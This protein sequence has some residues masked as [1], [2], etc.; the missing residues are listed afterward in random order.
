MIDPKKITEADCAYLASLI[1]RCAKAKV[2][3]ESRRGTT[4]RTIIL[5]FHGVS[6]EV[7]L[8]LG[9]KFGP[10]ISVSRQAGNEITFVSKAAAQVCVH[11]YPYLLV[12]KDV[13]RLVTRFASSLGTKHVPTSPENEA[14]R[15]EV[16]RELQAIDRGRGGRR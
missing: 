7:T 3:R 1:D 4:Y 16:D 2:R 10:L 13:A 6:D 9:E 12:M 11:A 5:Q 14:I 8:W 15:A